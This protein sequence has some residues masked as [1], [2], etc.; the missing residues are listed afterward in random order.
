M[1]PAEE[2]DLRQRLDAAIGR[3]LVDHDYA[4]SLLA[5]PQE[6]LDCQGLA[7]NYTA[8]RDLAEN[9]LRLFWPAPLQAITLPQ[10]R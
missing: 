2:R 10:C 1:T 8:L 3:A 4:D 6:A 9:L 5:R 7:D